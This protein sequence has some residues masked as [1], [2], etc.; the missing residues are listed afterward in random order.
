MV[1]KWEGEVKT[2]KAVKDLADWLNK[3]DIKLLKSQEQVLEAIR[4]LRKR[5]LANEEIEE[6]LRMFA[7]IQTK[8]LI[9]ARKHIYMLD[10]NELK[11]AGYVVYDPRPSGANPNGLD[12]ILVGP[13]FRYDGAGEDDG[14]VLLAL[15][16]RERRL[17]S[18]GECGQCEKWF[19]RRTI[20]NRFCSEECQ[21]EFWNQRRKTTEG[22]KHERERIRDWKRRQTKGRTK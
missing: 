22:R 6:L 8:F 17:E 21:Q 20:K 2:S 16:A 4:L 14:F 3:R 5:S 10:E 15:A 13:D 19:A 12:W 11:P 9:W 7:R 18:I 1:P